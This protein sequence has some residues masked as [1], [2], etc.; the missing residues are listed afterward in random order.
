MTERLR[1]PLNED[2]RKFSSM[3]DITALISH[4]GTYNHRVDMSDVKKLADEF[5]VGD[6]FNAAVMNSRDE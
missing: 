3:T 6:D 5:G 1:L 4:H 2:E